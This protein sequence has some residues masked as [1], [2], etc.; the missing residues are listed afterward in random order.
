[1]APGQRLPPSVGRPARAPPLPYPTLFR[2][3]VAGLFRLLALVWGSANVFGQMQQALNR[4]WNVKVVEGGMKRTL[5]KRLV[6]FG[7]VLGIDRKSTRLNSSHVKISYAVLC[8][9]NTIGC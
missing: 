6:S 9:Q 1:R 8:M 4:I 3:S 7:M 5:L 2:S